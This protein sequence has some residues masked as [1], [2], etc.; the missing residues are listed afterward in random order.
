MKISWENSDS[1]LL[2]N[3][4]YSKEEQA[5]FQKI[6][7][8]ATEWPGHFW[9]S[10]SGTSAPKWVGLSKSAILASASAVNKHLDSNQ[11]D[12]WVNPLPHFHVGG[13]GIL[14][15]AHL[16][17]AVC[18]D[19]KSVC[20]GKWRAADFY[21][22]LLDTNGTLTSLVPAQLQDLVELGWEAP[23]SLRAVIIGGG[24]TLPTLFERA[25]TLRWPILPS[26]GMTEC[27]SQIATALLDSWK[28]CQLPSLH[29]LPHLRGS[30][31]EGQLCFAGSSLLSVYAYLY[32]DKVKFVDPKVQ[33]WLKTEDR[34]E[35]EN[36]IVKIWGRADAIVKIGGENVDLAR[37]ENHVQAMKLQTGCAYDVTLV[38][39]QD[40]RLG[41]CIHL[42]SNS[43]AKEGLALLIH[44]F[45]SSV[46]PF[47]RIRKIYLVPELPRS[48]IGKILKPELMSQIAAIKPQ[49][50]F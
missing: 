39:V 37:L 33:G 45:Q 29:L 24:V 15:R 17:G 13:L 11:T 18:H 44:A 40:S 23:P 34:G 10:T 35:I 25:S 2:A 14:A 41:H 42:A 6:V 38:A 8:A 26:Y 19:F 22:Y 48:S 16:S 28:Q 9:L 1:Y 32:E 27:S 43:P 31:H 47:E 20:P 36:G 7:A 21:R 49:D 46:L 50:P 12:S 4:S 30:V 5:R 3:P